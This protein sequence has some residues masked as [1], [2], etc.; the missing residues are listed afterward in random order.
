MKLAAPAFTHGTSLGQSGVIGHRLTVLF[1]RI[2]LT[3]VAVGGGQAQK[4][5]SMHIPPLR[6]QVLFNSL[7][8]WIPR[9]GTKWEAGC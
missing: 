9:E 5:P 6:R 4:D 7:L 1:V 2:V 8:F 3:V